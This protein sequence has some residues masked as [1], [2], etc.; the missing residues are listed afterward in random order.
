MSVYLSAFT[1]SFRAGL[2][3]YDSALFLPGNMVPPL[4]L[5]CRC[6]ATFTSS[7]YPVMHLVQSALLVCTIGLSSLS[8]VYGVQLGGYGDVRPWTSRY[9][10]TE[11][12]NACELA[13]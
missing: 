6:A 9:V 13:A 4:M 10:I 2:Y 12:Y 1:I 5:H 3:V 8:Q 7:S 11:L